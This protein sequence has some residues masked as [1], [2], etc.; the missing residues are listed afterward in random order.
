MRAVLDQLR[1]LFV[2]PS[3][4]VDSHPSIIGSVSWTVILLLTTFMLLFKN[5]LNPSIVS[6]S[7][8][9][10]FSGDRLL[11]S[12]LANISAQFLLLCI[13]FAIVLGADGFRKLLA[14][15]AILQVPALIMAVFGFLYEIAF[16]P[17]YKALPLSG[18]QA[19]AAFDALFLLYPA[20]LMLFYRY[21]IIWIVAV[22]AGANGK[23]VFLL[24]AIHVVL[25]VSLYFLGG[26][27]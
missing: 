2:K 20:L 22:K 9:Q 4:A 14:N 24:I 5:A 8:V 13:P 25:C 27:I 3:Q 11:E 1:L 21:V 18:L 10:L 23:K 15:L 12:F 16:W 6:V 17:L 26:L 7:P 19:K